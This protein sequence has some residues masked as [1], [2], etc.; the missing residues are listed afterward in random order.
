MRSAVPRGFLRDGVR[1]LGWF[2]G[3]DS[4]PVGRI[5]GSV[6]DQLKGK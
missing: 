2:P 3:E 4:E 5:K 1:W 6:H